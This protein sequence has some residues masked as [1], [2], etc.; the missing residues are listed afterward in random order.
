VALRFF[1]ASAAPHASELGSY[2]PSPVFQELPEFGEPWE[3]ICHTVVDLQK[4]DERLAV[5]EQTRRVADPFGLR[6][7][8]GREHLLRRR[9]NIGDALAL[10]LGLH[11]LHA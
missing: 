10:D 4:R 8:D 2:S 5:G 7:I 11:H 9:L 1:T 6:R 3:G